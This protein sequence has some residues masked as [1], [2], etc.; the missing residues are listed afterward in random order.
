M[1]CPSLPHPLDAEW[2][3]KLPGSMSPQA[4]SL[5][6]FFLR[7]SLTQIEN[8][9][10]LITSALIC[11]S[12]SFFLLS[13]PAHLLYPFLDFSKGRENPGGGTLNFATK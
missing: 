13:L 1:P 12:Y 5:P 9:N 6:S 11:K 2:N 3:E 10:G 8:I 7:R 4:V